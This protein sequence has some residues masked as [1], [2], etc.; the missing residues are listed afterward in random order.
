V[1]ADVEPYAAHRCGWST[2]VSAALAPSMCWTCRSPLAELAADHFHPNYRGY[3][4]L[5]DVVENAINNSGK[6]F[7]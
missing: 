7:T 6:E 2:S 4:G 3:A 5:A 1:Q